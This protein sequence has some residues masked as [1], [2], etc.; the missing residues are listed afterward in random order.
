MK[1][2]FLEWVERI[3]V[4]LLRWSR[5]KLGVPVNPKAEY[6]EERSSK[7]LKDWSHAQSERE[8][9]AVNWEKTGQLLR[10]QELR[11]EVLVQKLLLVANEKPKT[12][13]VEAP[14]ET[15]D[16]TEALRAFVQKTLEETSEYL[17]WAKRQATRGAST[18]KAKVGYLETVGH[19]LVSALERIAN[20]DWKQKEEHDDS[21]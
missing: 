16:D 19:D 4:A 9:V 6:W 2:R 11:N 10:Q 17:G 8:R 14:K 12:V 21:V 13:V 18:W 15:T 1:R 5:T 7:L 20:G 3:S